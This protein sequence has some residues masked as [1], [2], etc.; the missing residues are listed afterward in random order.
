MER[1][2]ENGRQGG[3]K[4]GRQVGMEAGTE[5]GEREREG[6]IREGGQ[7]LSY[8][9]AMQTT[10]RAL[11]IMMYKQFYINYLAQQQQQPSCPC[12]HQDTTLSGE[13]AQP[14]RA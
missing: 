13:T 14:P 9:T 5:G 11:I 1:G 3:V 10:S 12:T 2:R 7:D 8:M 6:R 4:C